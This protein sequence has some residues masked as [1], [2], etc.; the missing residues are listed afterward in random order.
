M[1]L[2]EPGDHTKQLDEAIGFRGC[3]NRAIVPCHDMSRLYLP[4]TLGDYRFLALTTG[5]ALRR[6]SL[7]KHCRPGS[8]QRGWPEIV[9]RL[10][11]SSS[12]RPA[13]SA[14]PNLLLAALPADDYDRIQSA[15][16]VVRLKIRDFLYKPGEHIRYVYFPGGG[17]CSIVT[18]LKDGRMV[19]V[20][21]IG[22]EGMVGVSAVVSGVPVSSA[23]MVQGQTDTCYRM[24]AEAF[25]REMDRHG[26]FYELLTNYSQ[27]LVDFIMQSTACNAVHTVEQRLARWLLLARDRM[28]T[29][30]FPLTQE[31]VSMMLGVARP[32]VTIVAGTLQAAGLITYRRGE[33]AIVDGH[34]LEAASCECYRTA[35]DLLRQVTS[36][37]RNAKP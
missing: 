2:N 28:G 36:R 10:Q 25:R 12:K 21:T 14:N 6:D 13:A 5:Q 18:V 23:T 30:K 24:P 34:A 35:T 26:A 1:L 8:R 17:F 7:L 16:D 19:E 29:D 15:L 9:K 4:A 20:A 3:R 31:F 32:T 37:A 33:I 11:D 27:A 22:R